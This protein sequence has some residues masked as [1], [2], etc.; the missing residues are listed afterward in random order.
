MELWILRVV[1][2]E[3]QE[4]GYDRDYEGLLPEDYADL[5]EEE[6]RLLGGDESRTHLI[7]GLDMILLEKVWISG[8]NVER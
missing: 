2:K 4:L 5:T 3:R 7:K 1:A 6:L 8:R